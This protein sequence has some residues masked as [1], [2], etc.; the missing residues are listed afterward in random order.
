MKT[1]IAVSADW[2]LRDR[3]YHSA[4]RG[5][6]FGS[7][8]MRAVKAVIKEGI[9]TMAVIGD[10]FDHSA[11]SP[12][13]IEQLQKIDD[14]ARDNGLRILATTGNHDMRKPTWLSTLY[15]RRFVD[16]EQTGIIPFDNMTAEIDGVRI[17]GLPY[18]NAS[19]FRAMKKSGDLPEADIL[20]FHS[21]VPDFLGLPVGK[22]DLV[23]DD[24]PTERYKA[25]LLGD[26]HVQDYRRVDNCLVGY[27]GSTEMCKDNENPEKSV[28]VLSI[29]LESDKPVKME[30]R[31][32]IKTRAFVSGK[33]WT[34]DDLDAKVEEIKAVRDQRPVIAI[35]YDRD[36]PEVLSRIWGAAD[37][38]ALLV[39]CLLIPRSSEGEREVVQGQEQALL[40]LEEFVQ[41]EFEDDLELAE[42]AGEIAA[43]PGAD[44]NEILSNF[45]EKRRKNYASK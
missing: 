41:Q 1:K 23:L 5:K 33:I 7:A 3:Q 27:P 9:T 45:I 42:A 29:D 26:V 21:L 2:H 28:P 35:D 18:V 31:L 44:F 24:L 17:A 34:S 37:G 10:I 4:A 39:N 19:R 15:R 36:V 25:I 8:A 12:A 43:K 11:P 13:V 40:G 6:D 14:V 38:K 22:N 16:P 20:L 30:K 32:P